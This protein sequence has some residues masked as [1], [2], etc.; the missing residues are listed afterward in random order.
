MVLESLL[1]CVIQEMC[2]S[3]CRDWAKSFTAVKITCNKMK[4]LENANITIKWNY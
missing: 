2:P 1:K 3:A 4:I